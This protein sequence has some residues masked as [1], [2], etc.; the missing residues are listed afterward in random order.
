MRC[1]RRR[2]RPRRRRLHATCRLPQSSG[3]TKRLVRSVADTILDEICLFTLFVTILFANRPWL[4]K[5]P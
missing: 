4:S 2:G 5:P 1:A 3:A